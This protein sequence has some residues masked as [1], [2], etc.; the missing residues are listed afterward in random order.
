MAIKPFNSIDGFSVGANGNVVINTNGNVSANSLTVATSANLGT[1]ANLVIT[2]GTNKQF[3][4]TDGTGNLTFAD[5]GVATNVLYVSK[6]G[7]DS[8]DG[9]SLD[10]AKLTLAAACAIATSGTTIMLKSGDYTEINPVVVPAGVSIVGDNLRTTTLR[11][12]TTN[13]DILHLNNKCYVTGITFRSHVN[14]AA[15]VAFPTA[16]AGNIVTS[17]YVQ[18]CSSITTTGTG[19]RV[20]GSLATGL[21][22]MVTDAFTQ[23]N[24]GGI[25]I[26]I[27]NEGYAQLV[28]IFTICTAIGILCESGGSCS[29]TNSNN[30]FGDYALWSDGH[31]PLLYTGNVVNIVNGAVEV[32]NLSQR[33]IVNNSFQFAGDTAWYTVKTSTALVANTSIITFDQPLANTTAPSPGDGVSF[34]QPSFISASGQTFE[35]V[36]TGTNIANATPNLG[37]V[38]IQANEVIQANGGIVNWTSTDQFGDFRIGAGLLINE[39]AGVIT[40]TTFDKSLFAVLTPYIL[41]LEN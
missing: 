11:P 9:Q 39:E 5:A 22:S 10:T 35:Y 4:R 17:P 15:A 14:P 3:L 13:Q 20:D 16:G 25:G 34:Y 40:G 37:G 12:L 31:S 18:N 21:K 1:V 28:S 8:N 6:S 33:P 7:N 2:G 32:N 19:M 29:I 38:P 27:L 24:Q 41:A 26:H 30:S 36:G 23:Y